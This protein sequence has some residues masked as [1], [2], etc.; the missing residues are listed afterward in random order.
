MKTMIERAAKALRECGPSAGAAYEDA[1]RAV[2]AAIRTP[3]GR[4]SD[5][6]ADATCA[7]DYA[8]LRHESPPFEIERI[9][10]AAI[11]AVVGGA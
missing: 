6:L 8:C 4:L 1:A 7:S 2:I 11:D 10:T 9:Y 5:A 3:S